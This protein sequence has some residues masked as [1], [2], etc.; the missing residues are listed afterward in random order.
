MANQPPLLLEVLAPYQPGVP[1]GQQLAQLLVD[2]PPLYN[3]V[4]HYLELAIPPPPIAPQQAQHPWML[5]PPPPPRTRN[6]SRKRG[7]KTAGGKR[8][9]KSYRK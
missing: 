1:L 3:E 4:N 5:P 9:K 6:T 2:N 8:R 7:R